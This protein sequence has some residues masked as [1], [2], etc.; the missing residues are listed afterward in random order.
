MISRYAHLLRTHKDRLALAAIGQTL[1]QAFNMSFD[2]LLAPGLILWLGIVWGGL[3][4]MLIGL[5]VDFLS[6]RLYDKTKRD[7]LGF[8]LVKEVGGFL[9]KTLV[10]Q[11]QA[12]TDMSLLAKVGLAV[13]LSIKLNPFQV[14]ILLRQA[15]EYRDSLNATDQTLFWTSYVSGNLYWVLLM[16]GAIEVG[17]ITL[18]LWG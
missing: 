7:I 16:G 15:N 2:Y 8:E 10:R 6:I 5:P 17:R 12:L 11:Q 13:L 14:V 3:A 18:D 4:Y 1:Y 9:G